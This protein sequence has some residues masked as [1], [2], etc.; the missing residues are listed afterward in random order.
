MTTT[1]LSPAPQIA[2]A[3]LP[4]VT[5]PAEQPGFA[6]TAPHAANTMAI[7]KRDGRR[8]PVDVGKIVRAVQR[9]CDGLDDIDLTMQ[10]VEEIKNYEQRRKVDAPWLFT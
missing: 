1:L 3:T 4:S 7:T 10:H 5:A 8:E 9:C 6:L 2:S